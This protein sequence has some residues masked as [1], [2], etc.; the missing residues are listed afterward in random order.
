MGKFSDLGV[1]AFGGAGR[2]RAELEGVGV[3][4]QG[5]PA[6]APQ[7]APLR[8][9]WGAGG[10]ERQD[11]GVVWAIVGAE[12]LPAG[13]GVGGEAVGGGLGLAEQRA[14]VGAE[15]MMAGFVLYS[16]KD[17]AAE[18]WREWRRGE[19]RRRFLELSE[20]I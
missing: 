16:N 13:R 19:E 17:A 15:A 6:A 18:R 10:P 1:A 2:A 14:A 9:G 3:V 11:F 7:R 8:G 4:R 20:D 12:P 5:Q